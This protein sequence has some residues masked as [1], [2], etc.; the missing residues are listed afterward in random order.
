MRLLFAG[1][2]SLVF[3]IGAAAHFLFDAIG[4]W[5]P[6]GW[7]APVNESLW[8]HIKMAFWPAL[9]LDWLLGVRLPTIE[10]R[11][12]CTVASASISTLLIVP[13]F[14]GYT[15]VLGHH[16][17]LADVAIFAAAVCAGHWIA[18]RVAMGPVPTSAS[19]TAA[20]ALAALLGGALV[21][22]TYAPPPI[23]V[24]RDS[25]TGEFGIGS[26]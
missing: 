13:F 23:E 18:Y 25:L 6:I 21:V 12:V 2:A 11:V 7:I 10:H 15:S 26:T 8:E 9:A 22:F 17:L 19:V 16:Y 3:V 5:P 14:Y 4:R 20:V 1:E 24:F